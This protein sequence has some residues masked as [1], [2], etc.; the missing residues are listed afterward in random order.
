VVNS[1]VDINYYSGFE[2]LRQLAIDCTETYSNITARSG[3]QNSGGSDSFSFWQLGFPSVYFEETNFSPYWHTPGDIIDNYNMEYCAEVIKSSCATLLKNMLIPS[4]VKNYWAH[5]MGNGSSLKIGW[6]PNSEP[7]LLGYKIYVGT[8]SGIY[9]STYITTDTLYTINSLN[10]GT[11]YYIGVSA[12]DDEGYESVITERSAVPRLFPIPPSEFTAIPR[13]LE[14]DLA[15]NKNLEYDL[16]GYNLYRSGV[17]GGLG[18]KLHSQALTDTMFIDNSAANGIFYYYTVKAVD[19]LLN[20]SINNSTV[21]SR[22]ISLDQGILV[23]DE[24]D[25][26]DG[27]LMN[28][29]DEQADDFYNQILTHFNYQNY[30]LIEKGNIST[31]YLGAFST[32]LWH[33]NDFQ[34][35]SAPNDFKDQIMRYLNN[36]GNFLYV[37]YRPVRAFE[38]VFGNPVTFGPGDFIYDYLKIEEAAYN[39]TVLFSGAHQIEIGYNNIFIDSSK[40]NPAD[41]YHLRRIESITSSLNGN[42]IYSFETLFDSSTTQGSFIGKPVGVEYMGTDYKTITLSFPLYYMNQMQA[43]ELIDYILVNK[44]NEI[45]SVEE[46]ESYIPD[47]YALLQNYPNPF[48]PST[49]I[50]YSVPEDG[51]VRLTIYNLLGQAVTTLVNEEISAGNYSVVWNGKDQGGLKVSSGIYLYK[52]QANGNN[53]T[54]Y[55]QTKKMILL[56]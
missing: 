36:G 50:K 10:T 17:E 45:V 22:V 13:W 12:Y 9:D 16:L 47:E 7:D 20:E 56:K 55:S 46:E 5:D 28:P 14:V 26:G 34:D 54:P 42:N 6:S 52:M 53:G 41:E 40:T 2:Y 33:G 15:W 44:F 32:V 37:G 24:T 31:A 27:S 48:N 21:R 1:S 30:D 25:D 35:L 4:M 8:S 49:T 29:T 19:S 51:F 11:T 3:D 23:V 43:Q 18:D 39:T 38:Q